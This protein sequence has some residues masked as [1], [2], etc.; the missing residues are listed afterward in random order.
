MAIPRSEALARLASNLENFKID[1]HQYYYDLEPQ[2]VYDRGSDR[3]AG[4]IG[5]I[6]QH[7]RPV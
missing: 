4:C 7:P 3:Q 2:D 6:L 1:L 5:W